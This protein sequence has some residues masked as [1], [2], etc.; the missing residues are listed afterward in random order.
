VQTVATDG[1]NFADAARIDLNF[2]AWFLRRL[3]W[4][5]CRELADGE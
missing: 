5:R 2:G 1:R 3:D 4:L